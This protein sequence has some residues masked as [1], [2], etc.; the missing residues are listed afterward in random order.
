MYYSITEIDKNIYHIWEP[1]GVACTLIVGST[2]ALLIDTGYGFSDLKAVIDGLTDV[3]YRI[4]NT[5]GHVDHAGG[6][7]LFHQP[8]FMNMADL[9]VYEY[10]Q[11]IQKPMIID[12][13]LKDVTKKP[14]PW[15][16]GFDYTSYKRYQ[17]CH[18]LPLSDKMKIDLGDRTLEIIFLPG[19]TVGSVMVFD[20][21]S[22]LLFSGDNISDSLWIQFPQSEDLRKY[23]KNLDM[24][25]AY[26]I[27]GI[28]SS[29]RQTMWTPEILSAL[30]SAIDH[31]S[32]ENSKVF[33]HPRTGVESRLFKYPVSSIDG[34]KNIYIVFDHKRYV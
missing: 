33:I 5:H 2:E 32:V 1:A 18:F 3:P 28:I 30:K 26:P 27:K 29:H 21:S 17:P 9:E 11:R 20:W 24:L 13:F 4:M 31:L 22:G 16:E 12:K 8:I 19:H 14:L 23:R 7:Y 15:P 10:Y 25:D 6:N 34:I